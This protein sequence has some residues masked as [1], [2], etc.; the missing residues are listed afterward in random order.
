MANAP[1]LREQQWL[2]VFLSPISVANSVI[3]VS[4]TFGLHPK[5]PIQLKDLAGN[6]QDF[7][8]KR[9]L[10]DTQI[11]I[12][13]IGNGIT[14]PFLN[15]VQFDGGSLQMGEVNRNKFGS[16]LVLRAVYQEEPALALRNLLVNK[17]GAAIDTS[18]GVDGKISLKV[19]A[20]LQNQDPLPYTDDV[21][22]VYG[23]NGK[24]SQYQF[25]LATVL[26]YTVDVTY[27]TANKPIDYQTVIL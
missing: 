13:N 6:V 16:E 25:Y 8:I 5:A 24:A 27:N 12:G 22:I 26:K 1:D 21:K 10:N 14:G 11:Q 4:D 23:S 19:D 7:E 20:G 15:P 18:I 2:S 9:V 3:T 17:Y